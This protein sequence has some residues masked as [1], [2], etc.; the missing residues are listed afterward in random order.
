M[1]FRYRRFT[2]KMFSVSFTFDP[3]SFVLGLLLGI[4]KPPH[5]YDVWLYLML[6]PFVV[7]ATYIIPTRKG[8]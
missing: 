6:G 1:L 3:K 5:W 7:E 2:W 8:I 4:C